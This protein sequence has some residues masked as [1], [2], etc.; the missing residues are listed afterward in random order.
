MELVMAVTELTR[1]RWVIFKLGYYFGDMFVGIRFTVPRFC[2]SS[3]KYRS[4]RMQ[5][6][7]T[8]QLHNKFS[9]R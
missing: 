6:N 9:S 1:N 2:C 4:F 3:G 5:I 7:E 8:P